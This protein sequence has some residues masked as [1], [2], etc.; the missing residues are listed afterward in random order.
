MD[1]SQGECNAARRHLG[2]ADP[3][4]ISDPDR[5]AACPDD[6]VTWSAVEAL[7]RLVDQKR[8]PQQC[9]EDGEQVS[10]ER[11]GLLPEVHQGADEA[12][13]IHGVTAAGTDLVRGALAAG[14]RCGLRHGCLPSLCVVVDAEH[15]VVV[16]DGSDVGGCGLRFE[17]EVIAGLFRIGL[18]AA[19]FATDAQVWRDD[20]APADRAEFL[21]ADPRRSPCLLYTSPSP[22]DG[23]HSPLRRQR[24]MCI[25]D[26]AWAPLRLPPTRRYG[27]MMSPQPTGPSSWRRTRDVR[28]V[29]YTHLRAHET[30]S[31]LLFVGSVRCV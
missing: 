18:G 17:A 6:P 29:S 2:P 9:L 15:R 25:R 22:R 23:L 12:Q 16:D 7:E 24:Q 10:A 28:P 20:V 11:V 13:A 26:R 27:A 21:E 8:G 14:C 31:T 3:G 4:R 5:L 30:D 19:A 1:G